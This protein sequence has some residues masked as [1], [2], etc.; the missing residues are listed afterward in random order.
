[1]GELRKTDAAIADIA[2]RELKRQQETLGLIASEN[3]AS[4]AVLE[5]QASVLQ[6]KYSEGYSG[7]RYYAGNQFID[8]S[9]TLAIERAKKLFDAE[10]ANV[11]PHA[12]SQANMAV[13]YGLMEYGDKFLGLSLDQGGHL[14]HGSPVNFSGKLY[15]PIAYH[16]DKKTHLIDYDEAERLA[17]QEKPK[18]I[19][20]GY[21]A[22]P[23][24]IDFKRFREIADSTGAYLM[25]DIAHIAGLIAGKVHDNAFPY[26]DVVTTTT[27][28]TLRGPRGAMIMC[29]A[30]LA[31][32]ID[33]AVFPGLQGGPFDHAIA[34][35]AVCFQ[36][37]LQPSFKEYAK[38]IVK[39]AG[40]LAGELK[41]KGF[42]LS[43][44]GTDNHLLLAD[45]T[46]KV[47]SGKVA[48]EKLEKAG[49]ICNR[50]MIPYDAKSP[51]VTSGI[52]LG[53]P[54]LTTRGMKENE[55]KQ[56]AELIGRGLAAK[57]DAELAKLGEEVRSLALKFPIYKDVKY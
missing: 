36:E 46:N 52:R 45:V 31:Q 1:M 32:K 5:A 57:D 40:A 12:G 41:G 15:K 27:H 10:H 11:Q 49:I 28:K 7:K 13:F 25:A 16:L 34:A 48:Q 23:R 30:D 19:L 20:C 17:K 22:Y 3:Y 56:V 6:N 26:A 8:D 44:G 42:A 55:M 21:T 50:N 51:F 39:N 24:K 18:L 4:L 35:K 2:M 38:Q 9:E 14:T 47:E 54:C 37:A 43:S 29:K 53:T 33:K